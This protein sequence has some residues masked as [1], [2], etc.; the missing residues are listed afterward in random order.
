MSLLYVSRVITSVFVCHQALH[1][2]GIFAVAQKAG[3]YDPK[4]TRV[5]HVGFGVVL[6]EDK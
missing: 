3:F 2:D 6:G 1:M 5:E 4:T